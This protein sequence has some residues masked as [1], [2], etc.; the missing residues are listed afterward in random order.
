MQGQGGGGLMWSVGVHWVHWPWSFLGDAGQGQ[1][2]SVFCLGPP[3]L[4]YKAI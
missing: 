3:F 2:L 1:A 4:S